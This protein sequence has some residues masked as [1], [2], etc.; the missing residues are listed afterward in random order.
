MISIET[1]NILTERFPRVWQQIKPF[2]NVTDTLEKYRVVESK[3][4]LP[5]LVVKRE[6]LEYYIHSKYNP[7]EE[8]RKFAAQFQTGKNY[9]HIFFYGVGLG[10]HVEA[11][12]AQFPGVSFTIFEPSPEIL[13]RYLT[14]QP[15][16]QLSLPNL[17]Y[18]ATETT[19]DET[20]TFLNNFTN[21]LR[22]E[23]LM[24]TL[25]SYERVFKEHYT[26]FLKDFSSIVF[27]KRTNLR[28]DSVYQQKWTLN[29]IKNFKYLLETPSFFE[30]TRTEMVGKPVIIA[31]AGPSLLDEI[32]NLR[33]IKSQGL[34]YIFSAGSGIHPLL[35]HGIIPDAA[36]LYDPNDNSVV[37]NRIIDEKINNIPLIFGSSMGFSRFDE[38]Q[39]PKFHFILNQDRVAPYFLQKADRSELTIINDSPTITNV[40]FQLLSKLGCSPIIFVG[41]NFGFR[42]DLTYAPGIS[43]YN[44]N[45]ASKFKDAFL[46][47]DVYGGQIYSDNS[48]RMM[49]ENLEYYL[50]NRPGGEVYNA[51]KGGARIA[52]APFVPL[53]ELLKSKLT[54]S[55]VSNN[56]VN[57]TGPGYDPS[58]LQRQQQK[59][60]KEFQE[61]KGI[62]AGLEHRLERIQ[63]LQ[64]QKRIQDLE[65]AFAQVDR[66]I[67]DLTYNHFYK[68]FIAPLLKVQLDL[69]VKAV[70]MI[71]SERN[72]SVK[73]ELVCRDFGA[74][75]RGCQNALETVSEPY[76]QQVDGL[77]LSKIR[78]RH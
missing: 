72:P 52:G 61:V 1:V 64:R 45:D 34:A 47:E 12:L 13:Y 14:T 3:S 63:K 23:V 21:L 19:P 74:F 6:A 15:L 44:P 54:D 40:I 24:V 25:P 55:V 70:D 50:A 28:T 65:P 66:D 75:I 41:Q 53:E 27:Y 69:L 68:V 60:K 4:K 58:H 51:T 18:L 38:Y 5:T 17:K 46:I 56:W 11:I 10:Y 39:G 49:K 20:L 62:L 31:A 78:L 29:S 43:Y 7:V 22:D 2:E 73:A 32:E 48:Y 42:G 30:C 57:R 71:Q 37:Y 67:K 9:R 59:M 33:T 16:S 36:C 76:L 77:I 8:A 35:N 26:K